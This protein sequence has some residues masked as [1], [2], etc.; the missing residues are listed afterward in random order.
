[1]RLLVIAVLLAALIVLAALVATRFPGLVALDHLIVAITN[2]ALVAHPGLITATRIVTDLGSPVSVDVLTGVAV[3]LMLV[4]RRVR[5]AVYLVVVRVV[6]LAIETGLK[7]AIDRPRPA[8][9]VALVTASNSSFPSGHAAGTATLCVSLLL[10]TT[11]PVRRTTRVVAV[12]VAAVICLAVATSR[13]AL[14]VHYPSD[15]L[16]GLVLG[17][18]C[19]LALRPILGSTGPAPPQLSAPCE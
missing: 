5:A 16:A 15:V 18:L 17:S 14:G 4:R 10:C 1:M 9:A 13:V 3:V 7:Y 8:E 6:E 2:A 19:A 11:P 12:I